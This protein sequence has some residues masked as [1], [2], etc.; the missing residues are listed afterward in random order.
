VKVALAVSVDLGWPWWV[1]TIIAAAVAVAAGFAFVV[2]RHALARGILATLAV[3]GVVLAGVAPAVMDDDGGSTS[4]MQ[5]TAELTQA[6]FARR[7]DATCD[8]LYKFAATLGNPTTLP[9]TATMLD[10]LTPAAWNAWR[11]EGL[12]RPPLETRPVVGRWMNTMRSY[13]SSLEAVRYAARGGDQ[14]GVNAAN[15]LVNRHGQEAGR[16]S[17]QLGMKVCFH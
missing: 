15:S 6:G 1:T 17:S 11:Q 4:G 14:E 7:A 8:R 2:T 13:I 5:P 10:R 9:G 12:L 3:E 16:L